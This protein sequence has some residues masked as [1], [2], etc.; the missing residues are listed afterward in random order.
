MKKTIAR[1]RPQYATVAYESAPIV[2]KRMVELSKREI[3]TLSM[4]SGDAAQ[5]ALWCTM[6]LLFFES[7]LSMLMLPFVALSRV[8]FRCHWI[9]DTVVGSMIGILCAYF[10]FLNFQ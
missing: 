3:G 6:T 4:P 9:G 8:Y 2:P 7:N 10:G 1:V 5:G